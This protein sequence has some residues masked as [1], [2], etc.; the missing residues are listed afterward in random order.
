MIRDIVID[1]IKL[2]K[3]LDDCH[4]LTNADLSLDEKTEKFRR[5]FAT[6]RH[7]TNRIYSRSRNIMKGLDREISALPQSE[8]Q[9]VCLLVKDLRNEIVFDCEGEVMPLFDLN[10]DGSNMG[11]AREKV[12]ALVSKVAERNGVS[13][14]NSYI[15]CPQNLE[16]SRGIA[17][18]NV[19][20]LAL[21]FSE[22]KEKIGSLGN[23]SD[24][25][26]SIHTGISLVLPEVAELGQGLLGG[27]PL[28]VASTEITEANVK[29]THVDLRKVNLVGNYLFGPYFSNLSSSTQGILV[30]TLNKIRDLKPSLFFRACMGKTVESS[31]STGDH[32][33]ALKGIF[34]RFE[35]GEYHFLPASWD[36]RF[37]SIPGLN[38]NNDLDIIRFLEE[39]GNAG[40]EFMATELFAFAASDFSLSSCFLG[41]RFYPLLL[42]FFVSF[43]AMLVDGATSVNAFNH[44]PG[45]LIPAVQNING[46][47]VQGYV[48]SQP[49]NFE[50]LVNVLARKYEWAF[51]TRCIVVS[52]PLAYGLV[53][54]NDLSTQ[55]SF[56][57]L[58]E[59]IKQY[60]LGNRRIR[61]QYLI[62]KQLLGVGELDM[63][64]IVSS[65]MVTRLK[66]I[67]CLQ[68]GI[69]TRTFGDTTLEQVLELDD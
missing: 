50:L 52:D 64:Q 41:F 37:P 20:A 1:T 23:N 54:T 26:N 60:L 61:Q 22:V 45:F 8:Q 43:K 36:S 44:I 2:K 49:L 9:E 59:D 25:L 19:D 39:A 51:K 68:K 5:E 66:K 10:A 47:L 65:G 7:L 32:C 40:S 30:L 62:L 4:I 13:F 56:L 24:T 18:I 38:I 58:P 33:S 16:E 48:I 27:G 69:Y 35:V 57:R 53:S 15:N 63:S 34:S 14:A 28:S 55:I 11:F 42:P 3:S 46:V 17:S 21:A 67:L 6:T 12:A 29:E 31:P